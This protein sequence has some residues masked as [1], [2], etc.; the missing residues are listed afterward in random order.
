MLIISKHSGSMQ[1]RLQADIKQSGMDMECIIPAN[2][3]QSQITH[4][5]WCLHEFFMMRI[6]LFILKQTHLG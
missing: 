4:G 5:G 6:N 1:T 3:Q 2:L